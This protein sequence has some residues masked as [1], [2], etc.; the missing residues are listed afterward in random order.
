MFVLLQEG[1]N[2]GVISAAGWIVGL[3]GLLLTAV[4][5]LYLYR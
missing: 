2:A 4:W 3:G 1:V 5:L